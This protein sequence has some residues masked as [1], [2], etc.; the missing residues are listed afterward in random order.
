M[1]FLE[2]LKRLFVVISLVVVAVAGAIGWSENGPPHGC[3][4]ESSIKWDR[5][6]SVDY[7]KMTDEELFD[8]IRKADANGD[9]KKASEIAR[10]IENR[11]DP[12]SKDQVIRPALQ[13][14][15]ICP[16][17]MQGLAKQAAYA[18]GIGMALASVMFILWLCLRWVI[19]GFFPTAAR[20]T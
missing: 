20:K 11:S 15:V 5:T 1:N 12:W 10:A 2:G 3:V 17:K 14:L 16:P 4:E 7:S 8:S 6:P 19:V 18:A 13:P 9:A